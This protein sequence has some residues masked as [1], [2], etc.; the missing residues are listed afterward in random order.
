M[1]ILSSGIG[2]PLRGIHDGRHA[3][4]QGWGWTGAEAEKTW[5]FPG[6]FGIMANRQFRR[7]EHGMARTVEQIAKEAAEVTIY[8]LSESRLIYEAGVDSIQEIVERHMRTA[9]EVALVESALIPAL[10]KPERRW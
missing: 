1:Q 8:E 7:K 3:P 4:G 6:V 10:D 2:T 9:I 5:H